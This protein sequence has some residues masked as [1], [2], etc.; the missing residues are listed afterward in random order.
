M[1]TPIIPEFILLH[2]IKAGLVFIKTD[3][4]TQ[5]LA[6]TPN[7]SYLHRILEDAYIE[8]YNYLDQAKAILFKENDDPRR[9]RVDLMYNMDFEKVPSIYITL[10]GEQHGANALAIEQSTEPYFNTDINNEIISYTNKYT[11][12][13]NATYAIYITSDNSNEVTLLYHI[14]DCLIIS[15]TTHLGLKGLYNITQGGQDLQIDSDKIPKH[16]FIKALSIGLQYE[17]SAP[18]LNNTP[19]FTDILFNSRPTG[20]KSDATDTPNNLDDI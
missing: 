18:D 2:A 10:P 14:I 6:G 5:M 19:T 9:L 15:M 20:L 4:D 1:N 11:R 16:L 3:F 12:R 13:K 8:R 7:N 17:R